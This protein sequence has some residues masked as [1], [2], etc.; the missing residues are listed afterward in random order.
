[1]KN[2][3][4]LGVASLALFAAAGTLSVWLQQSKTQAV[5]ED[6]DKEKDSEKKGLKDDKEKPKADP[7]PPKGDGPVAAGAEQ[8]EQLAAMRRREERMAKEKAQQALILEDIR[9]QR[10]E[11]DRLAKQ[12]A[13]EATA[14]LARAAELAAQ[15]LPALNPVVPAVFADRP[16]PPN[17]NEAANIK[18]LALM[19]EAMAPNTAAK[20][21]QEMADRGT[22]DTAVQILG[23]M[24]ERQA[25]KVIAEIADTTLAAQILE[26]L[27]QLK[28]PGTAGLTAGA[29][30]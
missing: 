14:A 13:I 7:A 25:G 10:E 23:Q 28:R 22:M 11:V 27:R 24:R 8:K 1:M 4:I 17:P 18:R 19:Y 6:A 16:T 3:L 2:Y 21:F 9:V 20:I 26:K 12:V 30:S 5:A 15:P 29:G